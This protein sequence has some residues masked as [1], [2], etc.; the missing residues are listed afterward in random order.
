MAGQHRLINGEIA[1]SKV[2]G[3]ALKA[4]LGKMTE[5]MSNPTAPKVVKTKAKKK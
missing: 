5:F 4:A 1:Q 2:R 3:P